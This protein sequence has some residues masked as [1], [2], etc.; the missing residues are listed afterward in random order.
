MLKFSSVRTCLSFKQDPKTHFYIVLH[1]IKL[2]F[3]ADENSTL[4]LNGVTI[5]Q[6]CKN[7]LL[8]SHKGIN[9]FWMLCVFFLFT[10]R[11]PP[12]NW[13]RK[14]V[15]TAPFLPSWK[16]EGGRRNRNGEER[17][18]VNTEQDPNTDGVGLD[19][20]KIG[21]F[22]T[23]L[24]LPHNLVYYFKIFVRLVSFVVVELLPFPFPR[25]K[26]RWEENWHLFPFQ[27]FEKNGRGGKRGR[28]KKCDKDVHSSFCGCI[29]W[30]KDTSF[31]N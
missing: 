15:L 29:T 19:E 16:K 7:V 10:S 2:T 26:Q 21:I 24:N 5:S 11:T 23:L 6:K 12:E 31:C 9:F 8:L 30:E 14:R 25:Q 22:Q 28:R 4:V 27:R 13:C 17:R 18:D 3:F 20:R 1:K